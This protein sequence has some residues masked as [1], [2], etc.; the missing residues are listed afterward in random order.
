VIA[1]TGAE[2]TLTV[3][4][5][6]VEQ[7]ARSANLLHLPIPL[8]RSVAAVSSGLGTFNRKTETHLGLELQY[9]REGSFPINAEHAAGNWKKT[10]ALGSLAAPEIGCT[11]TLLWRTSYRLGRE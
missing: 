4:K 7:D 11:P 8:R 9:P 10:P 6:R 2:G 3:T 1:A 5:N